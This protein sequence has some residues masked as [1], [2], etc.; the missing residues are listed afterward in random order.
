MSEKCSTTLLAKATAE[1]KCWIW[2]IQNMDECTLREKSVQ[3]KDNIWTYVE[4]ILDLAQTL[5]TLSRSTLFCTRRYWA[6]AAPPSMAC[7]A[8]AIKMFL[9]RNTRRS[10]G[11]VKEAP[12]I[13][14]RILYCVAPLSCLV[15]TQM[16]LSASLSQGET[17]KYIGL[18][19]SA[20][21][22]MWP[23]DRLVFHSKNSFIALPGRVSCL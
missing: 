6:A 19:I 8:R 23:W 20:A 13:D 9:E 14:N 21:S 3:I 17:W 7:R 11:R 1:G 15:P 5:D 2:R 10:N 22:L 18:P 4:Q 16:R 12:E